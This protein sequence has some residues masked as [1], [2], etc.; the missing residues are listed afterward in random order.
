MT[1]QDKILEEVT[2]GEYKFGFVSDFEADTIPKG[3]NEAVI[4]TISD[5]KDEPE[6]LLQFRLEAFRRWEKMKM[7][8]WPYLRIPEINY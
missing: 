8:D 2:S 7:P 5:K 1:E 4:R 3:L 6:F